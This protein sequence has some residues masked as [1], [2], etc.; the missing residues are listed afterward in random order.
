MAPI[1]TYPKLRWPIEVRLESVEQQQILL[2]NCPIGVSPEPLILV[3]AIAPIVACFDGTQSI[4][5]ILKKYAEYGIQRELINELVG[6][7]DRGLFLD[8]P[9]F[10][11]AQKTIIDNFKNLKVR[12]PALAGRSYSLHPEM[13]GQEIDGYLALE[14]EAQLSSHKNMVGLISPHIDYR[15]GKLAYAKAWRQL[16]EDHDLYIVIGTSHQ[17]SQLLFHL[18]RKDFDCPLGVAHC[19]TEFVDGLAK[20]YGFERSFADEIVHRQEHSLE[21]QIPFLRRLK[22]SPKIV[23][24]LVG[25][26]HNMVQSGRLPNEFD[27]YESFAGALAECIHYQIGLGRRVCVVAG[28]DMAHVGKHFGDSTNLTPEFMDAIRLRDQIYLDT[29]KHQDKKAMFAHIAEDRD[30]RRICGFP[31]MY[32]ILDVF[33]RLGIAYKTDIFDYRQAVDYKTDCAVT[34]AGAGLYA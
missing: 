29:I 10:H 11:A 5:D 21:L 27:E 34:F 19:D 6:L 25:S 30:A 9:R 8:T 20:R 2:V 32:T 24:I 15:R 16:N 7:L 14:A 28:V 12:P 4:D 26:F 23:P 1:P 13:L 17:Y 18:S 31:T 3:P 22:S 33:D